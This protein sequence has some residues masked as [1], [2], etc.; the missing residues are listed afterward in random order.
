MKN[1]T[2]SRRITIIRETK[3]PD[4]MESLR[5]RLSPAHKTSGSSSRLGKAKPALDVKQSTAAFVKK[6]K[7]LFDSLSKK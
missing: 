7:E 2:R 5:S 3:S 4:L 1:I 6:N